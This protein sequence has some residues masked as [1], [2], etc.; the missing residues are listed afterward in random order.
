MMKRI[1]V[2][3][4]DE[5]LRSTLARLLVRTGYEVAEAGEGHEAL[6][7]MA[8]QTADLVIMDMLMPDMEGAET[9]LALRR[10]YPGVKIVAISG[11]G[12]SSPAS[13]LGIARALG[14]HKILSKPLIPEEFLEIIRDLLR[15]E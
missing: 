6:Q 14:A 10:L 5:N 7:R 12:I 1:L 3:E 15:T 2:V 11:G 4:D 9:I 8:L 13:L